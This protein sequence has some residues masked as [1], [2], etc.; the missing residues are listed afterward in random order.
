[1]D[2]LYEIEED[3]LTLMNQIQDDENNLDELRYLFLLIIY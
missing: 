3:N 2:L 1:M